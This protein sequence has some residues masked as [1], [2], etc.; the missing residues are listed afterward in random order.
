MFTHEGK[1]KIPYGFKQSN[2][3]LLQIVG[4]SLRNTIDK[5]IW[6]NIVLENP[7]MNRHSVITD[8]R[9]DNEIYSI[10]KKGGIML[11]IEGDPYEIRK[12]NLSNRDLNHS[13]EIALDNYKFNFIIKNIATKEFQ[14]FLNKNREKIFKNLLSDEEK[15][16]FKILQKESL[17]E[18][19]KK[20]LFIIYPIII[21]GIFK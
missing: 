1:S 13:T 7:D 8:V 18:L 14:E 21:N 19:R 20:V 2:G 5:N 16:E 15:E 6:I 10:E 12:Y 17:N 9:H 11:R 4:E 3:Q